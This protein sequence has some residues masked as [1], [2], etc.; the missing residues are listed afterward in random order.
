MTRR[1]KYLLGSL[2]G[3]LILTYSAALGYLAVSETSLVF[4]GAGHSPWGIWLPKKG[5]MPWDSLRIRG[6][7]GVPVF[8]MESRL[9]DAAQRPWA[10]YF[11]GNAGLL[12]S[13]GNVG[14]Y[15]LLREAGFNVLAV[16]YRGYGASARSGSPS[17]SGFY[18]DAQAA[19]KHLTRSLEVEPSRVVVYGWSLGSGPAMYLAAEMR[20]AG[21]ITEGAFTSLPDV[22]AARYPWVPAHLVMRNRFD[23]LARAQTLV[24]PWIL[25]HSVTDSKV[26]FSHGKRLAAAAR[27]A[28]LIPL[29]G[30]HDDGVIADR[31]ITLPALRTLAQ[32]LRAELIRRESGH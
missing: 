19:W 15:R 27:S 24:I 25:F 31:T 7:D 28:Q 20:P 6:D 21:V 14:R 11:H 8:L 16:E 13:R 5:D 23:N 10:I 26:P 32:Q 22:G 18:A 1:T 29:R 17:E 2:A 3:V 9:D 12:G 4:V 30:G